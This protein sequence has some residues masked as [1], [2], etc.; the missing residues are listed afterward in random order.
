M[1]QIHV[2]LTQVAKRMVEAIKGPRGGGASGFGGG[3][4]GGGRGGARSHYDMDPG[5]SVGFRRGGG[6][7][8]RGGGRGARRGGYP[9]NPIDRAGTFT[10]ARMLNRPGGGFFNER[11]GAGGGN[12]YGLQRGQ[13][14]TKVVSVNVVK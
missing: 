8:F 10:R 14:I 6:G 4:I 9:F 2:P 1:F 11:G 5:M 12:P 3:G 13:G 7:H